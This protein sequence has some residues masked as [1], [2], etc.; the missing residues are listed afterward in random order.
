MT[1]GLAVAVGLVAAAGTAGATGAAGALGAAAGVLG[2]AAEAVGADVLG[3][4]LG[5]VAAALLGATAAAVV[6]ALPVPD[7]VQAVAPVASSAT[8]GT[9]TASRRVQDVSPAVTDFAIRL[10][11]DAR[12]TQ[13][14]K[15]LAVVGFVESSDR[16]AGRSAG[17]VPL[18][19]NLIDV[20]PREGL[21]VVPKFFPE[22]SK[23]LPGTPQGGPSSRKPTLMTRYSV[24]VSEESS[25]DEG[26]SE[27]SG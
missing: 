6:G 3:T 15:A 22:A 27:R 5:T 13:P 2:A 26:V 19:L 4:A 24:A 8:S 16:G 21:Q 20:Q 10:I 7:P 12:M 9:E 14:P 1:I 23:R 17:P 11:T 18:A 25:S